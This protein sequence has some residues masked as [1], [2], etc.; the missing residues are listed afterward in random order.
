[1]IWYDEAVR[2]FILVVLCLMSLAFAGPVSAA[3]ATGLDGCVD[4]PT[5][6]QSGSADRTDCDMGQNKVHK[7]GHDACCGY[8]LV[9]ISAVGDFSTLP[10]PRPAAVASVTKRLTASGWEPLLDPPRA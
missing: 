9:A 7:C 10:S 6:V 4:S 8:H 1:V 5:T 2:Y 3:Y